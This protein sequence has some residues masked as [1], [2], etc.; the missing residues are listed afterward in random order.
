MFAKLLQ[1]EDDKIDI[2]DGN[3]NVYVYTPNGKNS[4]RIFAWF[5]TTNGSEAYANVTDEARYK[6]LLN[7]IKSNSMVYS[8]GDIDFSDMPEI[9]NLST[10]AET[11]TTDKRFVVSCVRIDNK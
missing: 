4:Y 8:P 7:Y 2:Y 10:C 9:L 3:A 11:Y 5:T 6:K 1:V